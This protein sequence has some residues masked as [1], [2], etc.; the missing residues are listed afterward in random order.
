[1]R[2]PLYRSRPVAP[3]AA[4]LGGERINDFI[5]MS[6]GC[7]NTYLIETPDGA[8]L[9]NAGMAFEAPIHLQ[10]FSDLSSHADNIKYVIT[11]QGHVDHVGGVALFRRENPGLQYIAQENNP[12]HQAY[13]AR[14]ARYRGA[15]SSFRFA[16]RFREDARYY[17][18]NGYTLSVPHEPSTPDITFEDRHELQLGGLDIILIAAKGAETND[19]LVV[20]LPQHE[21]C[22]TGNL[23]GCPFGHFPNL[24]TIRGDRYRDAL[25]CAEAAQ[26][27]LDLAPSTILYGHHAPIIGKDLIRDELTAYRDAILYVHDEVV[28]GMNEGKSVHALMQEIELPLEYEVGQGYGKVSW[29]IRAIWE[30]Y[31]G[32]FHH[33]STTELYSIPQREIFQDITELVGVDA[34]FERARAKFEGGRCEEALHLLDIVLGAV[35]DHEPSIDLSIEV[36]EKLLVGEENFW[37]EG[38]LQNQIK[39]LKEG[40]QA[41]Y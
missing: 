10:N 16:D 19:S 32:W 22:L 34:L 39:R 36:H 15:R 14:L 25:T 35:P 31:S 12:E 3:N 21:I 37:L 27:V 18:E 20:W 5:V 23:F 24:V 6:E 38:W 30:N 7:S 33:E 41:K 13:E 29:S 11:T 28:K 40:K 1:M 8:I 26:T 17:N 4:R 2:T 9:I